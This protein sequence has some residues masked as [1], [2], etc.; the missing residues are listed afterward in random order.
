MYGWDIHHYEWTIQSET[1][2]GVHNCEIEPSNII[3]FGRLWFSA[4]QMTICLL[5]GSSSY[6]LTKEQSK[7]DTS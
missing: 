1:I 4:G 5:V 3:F 2:I 6:Y 7:S